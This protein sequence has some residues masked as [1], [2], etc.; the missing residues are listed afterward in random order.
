LRFYAVLLTLVL[1]V[2]FPTQADIG[3]MVYHGYCFTPVY[4]STIRMSRE[5][6]DIYIGERVSYDPHVRQVC[7]SA[8]FY[9]QNDG[10]D[11]VI[12]DVG[13]PASTM[14]LDPDETVPMP[15]RIAVAMKE[16]H[17]YDIYDFLVSIDGGRALD[18]LPTVV[19]GAF[20]SRSEHISLWYGWKMAFPPG[21]TTVDVEYR[22]RTN[23]GNA[24]VY[25]QT[26]YILATGRFWKGDIGEA[27]VTVHLPSDFGE[28]LLGRPW[29]QNF[30][31]VDN[32]LRWR[33]TEY[34]PEFFDNVIAEFMP[35]EVLS[36]LRSLEQR[37]KADPDDQHILLELAKKYLYASNLRGPE[38]SC[39]TN[40]AMLAEIRLEKLLGINPTN[41]DAWQL[42]LWNYHR[43]RRNSFGV[44]W[45]YRFEIRDKQRSLV[46][47]AFENCPQ[48]E[49]I[50]LWK[51]L[52]TEERWEPLEEIGYTIVEYND[53]PWIELN[54]FE[55]DRRPVLSRRE[56]KVI[57]TYY[58]RTES[59]SGVPYFELTAEGL[60]ESDKKKILRVLERRGFYG[61]E[62]FDSLRHFYYQ[63]RRPGRY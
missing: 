14:S 24:G 41:C 1:F 19:T 59:T 48:D 28:I 20:Y 51:E 4:S 42:Y 61:Y 56:E 54:D 44:G 22:V 40:F 57:D 53:E 7:V 38:R 52:I 35:P 55:R 33:W 49:A 29:P 25:Q 13:F 30:E 16:N 43:I 6:V 31:V 21:E 34:E 37:E 9:M 47:S 17:K 39:Y 46:E 8:R 62:N 50:R 63:R 23:Y 5:T 18:P 60:S 26:T 15:E 10:M 2:P 12:V 36:E 11:T 32:L 45:G 27:V 58:K 3:P